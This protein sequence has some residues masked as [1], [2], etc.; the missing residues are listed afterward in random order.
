MQKC[1]L[2]LILVLVVT[3]C[4]STSSQEND[5]NSALEKI[6]ELE[7][8]ILELEEEALSTVTT[9]EATTTTTTTTTTLS[10]SSTTTTTRPSLYPS[11]HEFLT[12]LGCTAVPSVGRWN[13]DCS[14]LNLG[15]VN[16]SKVPDGRLENVDF[17]GS[18]LRGAV[19]TGLEIHNVSF[20][21]SSLHYANFTETNLTSIRFDF[22]V[23]YGTDFTNSI[24][25]WSYFR[26]AN[27]SYA[28]FTN[29]S[30]DEANGFC[31]ENWKY[32]PPILNGATFTTSI[33]VTEDIFC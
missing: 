11:Q 26:D 21:Y 2:F 6:E 14:F 10:P 32:D 29:V 33:F 31:G 13:Y 8:Q 23:A 12:D 27:F 9:S 25:N 7:N 19:F 3:A 24:L 28:D 1:S 18:S 15:G 17:E 16:F 22:A 20:Y 30:W 4:G 5:L